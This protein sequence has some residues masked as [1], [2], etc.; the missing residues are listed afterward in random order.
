MALYLHSPAAAKFSSCS[1]SWVRKATASA[2]ISHLSSLGGLNVIGVE[3]E[4][5]RERE[6]E[7]GLPLLCAAVKSDKV[8]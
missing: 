3:S 1:D 4:S 8:H 7:T 6:R 5:E 2:A